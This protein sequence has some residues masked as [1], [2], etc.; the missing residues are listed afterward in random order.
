M[1]AL[2]WRAFRYVSGEMTEDEA[3]ELEEL[4]ATDQTAREAVSRAVAL[5]CKLA[6]ARPSHEPVI[7][8]SERSTENPSRTWTW[9]GSAVVW[10]AM[11]TAASVAFLLGI[12][13]GRHEAVNQQIVPAQVA[14][15][16]GTEGAVDA[17][18]WLHLHQMNRGEAQVAQSWDEWEADEPFEPSVDHGP[19]VPAWLV[20]LA[21]ANRTKEKP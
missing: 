8:R 19:V 16:G 2:E 17:D 14:R 6:E 3:R 9:Q 5:G 11:A 20:D 7:T 10:A 15:S 12:Y 13:W 18:A 21:S 1:N 4:M